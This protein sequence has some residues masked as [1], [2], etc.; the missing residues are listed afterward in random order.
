MSNLKLKHNPTSYLEAEKAL[1]NR[2]SM[3]IGHNTKLERNGMVSGEIVATYHN[4]PIVSYTLGGV[5]ASWAGWT[6]QTTASRLN[7]LTNGA[8]N[9][10]AREPMVNGKRVDST[11]WVK[12]S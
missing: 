12:V 8:F 9:I 10:K 6:T 3:T 11:D 1:G 5:W 4:N 2:E 7:K